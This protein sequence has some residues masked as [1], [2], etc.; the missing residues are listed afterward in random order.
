MTMK[1]HFTVMQLN[2]KLL[3]FFLYIFLYIEHLFLSKSI[4]LT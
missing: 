2:F 1:R 3:D 4:V